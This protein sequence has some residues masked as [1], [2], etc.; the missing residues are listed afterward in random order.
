MTDAPV[1]PA[2]NMATARPSATASAASLIDARGLRR[3]ARAGASA[4]PITS[5]ASMIV[6]SSEAASACRASSRSI[7]AR[8]PARSRPIG[9]CRADATAPSMIGPGA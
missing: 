3:S 9:R 2:L 1:L 4:M 5:G 7:A 6:M 8:G